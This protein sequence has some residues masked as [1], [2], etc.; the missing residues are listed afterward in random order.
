MLSRVG[1]FLPCSKPA[2]RMI[3]ASTSL[4]SA[5]T[6][7]KRSGATSSR[8]AAKASPTRGEAAAADAGSPD[9]AAGPPS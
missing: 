6:A 9:P 4:P 7:V 2:G 5:E 8:P 3:Q 1:Y